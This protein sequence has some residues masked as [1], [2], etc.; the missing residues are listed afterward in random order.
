MD[1]V[2]WCMLVCVSVSLEVVSL[3]LKIVYSI[4]SAV[5]VH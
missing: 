2:L 1:C 4:R 3:C 5:S